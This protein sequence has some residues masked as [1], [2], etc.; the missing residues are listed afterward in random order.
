V[1]RAD[2][3]DPEILPLV[4]PVAPVRDV[5]ALRADQEARTAELG[6]A[7]VAMAAVRERDDAPVRVREYVP[8]GDVHGALVYLH[9]G[10]WATGSVDTVDRLVRRLARAAGAR[11][12]SI[13][14]RLA[15]EHPFPAGLEDAEAA[16]RW[17]AE[18]GGPLAVAGDSAGGNLAAVATRRTG[19]ALRL[20]VLLYPVCDAEQ[21]TASYADFAEGFRL[22]GEDMAW[23]F[24]L[25]GGD[26]ADPD[27]SPVRAPLDALR[28]LPPAYVL[29]ASH[30]VLRDEG[31]AYAERLRAA[32]VPVEVRRWPGV[33]HGFLR[34][35][36]VVGAART[37]LDEV[38]AR[39]RAALRG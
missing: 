9:G 8:E 37:A 26:P 7:P 25:Y 35:P 23:F 18:Q 34:W 33:V 6:G 19:V 16:L 1:R 39:V 27:V 13:G 4:E 36:G 2:P 12:L 22:S 24:S 29:T 32:G 28:G 3:L 5:A 11:V 38:G 15:P 10:G 30:D 14:Y 17:V 31:E 20:Q 21:T